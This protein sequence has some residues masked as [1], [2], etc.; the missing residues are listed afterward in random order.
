MKPQ[1]IH[2]TATLRPAVPPTEEGRKKINSFGR[3]S[4][5]FSFGVTQTKTMLDGTV[6]KITADDDA[7]IPTLAPKKYTCAKC[8]FST[9]HAPALTVHTKT[10]T[11]AA[12]TKIAKIENVNEWEL[13]VQYTLDI[14]AAAEKKPTMTQGS[15]SDAWTTH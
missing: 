13:C 15:G 5:L 6:M 7:F 12:N 3:Q 14:V 11:A 4:S 2:V 9:S 8:S 1:H 10:H